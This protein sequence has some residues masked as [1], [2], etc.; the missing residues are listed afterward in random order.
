[1]APATNP[2]HP[3]IHNLF[4]QQTW[5]NDRRVGFKYIWSD[6]EIPS[7]NDGRALSLQ[8]CLYELRCVIVVLL[9]SLRSYISYRIYERMVVNVL[10]YEYICIKKFEEQ[11]QQCQKNLR[12]LLTISGSSTMGSGRWSFGGKES[13]FFRPMIR[14]RISVISSCTRVCILILTSSGVCAGIRHPEWILPWYLEINIC[15]LLVSL[16]KSRYC[17]QSQQMRLETPILIGAN[18]VL[19]L[20][21]FSTRVNSQWSNVVTVALFV[22]ATMISGYLVLMSSSVA[23]SSPRLSTSSLSKLQ[24]L[25]GFVQ[26]GES[27]M[28]PVR[29]Y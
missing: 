22:V 3:S 16:R 25:V 4:L 26:F 8:N 12:N 18:G 9:N 6:T 21:A 20:I 28:R 2:P 14:S 7:A 19:D 13:D 29:N 15:T 5:T 11:S 24:T 27:E 17:S 10:K 1:M 23:C